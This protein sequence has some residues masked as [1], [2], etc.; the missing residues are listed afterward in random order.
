VA[1][2]FRQSARLG[3]RVWH[4][5]DLSLARALWGDPAVARFIAV[6]ALSEGQTRARLEHE[7]E[8]QRRYGIQY[9]PIFLV[10]T[11]EHIGCCGLRPHG[12]DPGTPEFGVHIA[13]RHWRQGYA[14]E[15]ASCVIDHAFR[16]VGANALFAGHNPSN[17]ASH[18]LLTRLGFVYTHDEFYEPTG[19]HHPSYMLTRS[20]GQPDVACKTDPDR[21][22][23]DRTAEAG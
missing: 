23:L 1:D 3:F 8:T 20:Q 15:A 9:W 13:S 14:F 11:G 22:A 12:A 4:E 16:I 6:G 5:S 19:L 18:G 21:R 7:I 10:A 2:Y 17:T